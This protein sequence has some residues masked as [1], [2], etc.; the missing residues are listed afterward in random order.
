MHAVR[1]IMFYYIKAVLHVL[2][3]VL[4]MCDNINSC[5]G[6]NQ[7]QGSFL[8]GGRSVIM[9]QEVSVFLS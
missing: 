5:M 8:W 9:Q 4:Y 6:L 1:Y 3:Y 2:K 7:T